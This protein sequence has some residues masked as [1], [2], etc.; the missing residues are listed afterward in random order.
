MVKVKGLK[1]RIVEDAKKQQQESKLQALLSKKAS[2]QKAVSAFNLTA[3][4]SIVPKASV[5]I[6]SLTLE[7]SYV[8]VALKGRVHQAINP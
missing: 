1:H 4:R 6:S 5:Q 3:T 8:I 2:P 7:K